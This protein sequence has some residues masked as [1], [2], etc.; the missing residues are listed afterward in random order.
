M[1]T[2]QEKIL[3]TTSTN[4]YTFIVEKNSFDNLNVQFLYFI[5]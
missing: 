1:T 3:K 4:K 5:Q 2:Y